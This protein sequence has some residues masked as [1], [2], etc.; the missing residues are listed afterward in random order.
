MLTLG[1]D[2]LRSTGSSCK[3]DAADLLAELDRFPEALKLY[4][5]V[6]QYSLG[7]Q[8]TKYNVKEYWL[9][10]GLCALAAQVRILPTSSLGPQ[11]M[12]LPGPSGSRTRQEEV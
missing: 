10:A 2:S 5:E 4:D 6:A 11:T 8:L 12:T 7:S 9:R 3:K 1:S